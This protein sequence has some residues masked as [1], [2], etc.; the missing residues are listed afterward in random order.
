MTA[1]IEPVVSSIQD[2]VPQTETDVIDRASWLPLLL[3]Y[4]GTFVY[5]TD[6]S[7]FQ[8]LI[9]DIR[10]TFGLS[11]A[12]IGTL[13]SLYSLAQLTE[14][15]VSYVGDRIRR[16]WLLVAEMLSLS[17]FT[18]TAG[19]SGIVGKSSLAFVSRAGMGVTASI[20]ATRLSLLS[21][22]NP[23]TQRPL[24]F[25]GAQV[26]AVLGMLV[27]PA[28]AGLIGQHFGWESPFLILSLPAFAMTA[29]IAIWLREP[30]RGQFELDEAPV[31]APPFRRSLSLVLSRPTVRWYYVLIASTIV[32]TIAMGTYAPVLFR[33]AFDVDTSNLGFVIA[34][35]AGFQFASLIVASIAMR[36][37]VAASPRRA[38]YV[39]AAILG[40][41]G[42]CI[43]ALPLAPSVA[44]AIVAYIAIQGLSAAIPPGVLSLVAGVLPPTVRTFGFGLTTLTFILVVPILPLL[45]VLGDHYGVRASLLGTAPV[46]LAGI[47]VMYRMSRTVEA[48]MARVGDV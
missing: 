38:L 28:L 17:L 7:I 36:K 6:G 16:T 22:Y 24:T 4:A 21:D 27:G 2:S 32:S 15:I 35:A 45:G 5:I 1:D 26:P 3:I 12:A 11:L 25:Y 47:A 34:G 37:A 41:M 43:I 46:I 40:A 44:L 30:P 33:D 13:T 31:A 42:L 19:L 48:D 14:P 18:A 10:K 29:V 8:V 39:L 9:P 20:D 23:P